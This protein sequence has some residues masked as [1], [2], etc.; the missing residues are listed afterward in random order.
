MKSKSLSLALCLIFLAWTHGNS[1]RADLV[2]HLAGDGDAIDQTGNGH[3]GTLSGAS[4]GT[5]KF[6]QA[7]SFTGTNDVVTVNASSDLEPTDF[8][9]AMWI[10]TN[11]SSSGIKLLMDSSHGSSNGPFG[12]AVQMNNGRAGLA[13][14]NG[15]TFP[16][17]GSTIDIRNSGFRHFA[18]T[19]GASTMSVYLDGSLDSTASFTG[20]PMGT[21]AQI[22]LGKHFSL[23]R[24][25]SGLLDDVRIYNHALSSAE[26]QQLSSVPEPSSLLTS[27]LLLGAMALRR[28]K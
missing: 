22:R 18:A 28:R 14:G 21:G 20:T 4:F 15:S 23:N 10:N 8:S 7:F 1:A 3:N 11:D 24:Q 26:V 6:G 9:V 17:L 5:G 2:M 13:Y 12:W 16:G 19:I 25:F 27:F